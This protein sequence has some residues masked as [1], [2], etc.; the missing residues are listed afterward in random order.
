LDTG[1]T[2]GLSR[3]V[4][5]PV[6]RA[7]GSVGHAFHAL[8]KWEPLARPSDT[9][10]GG[11]SRQTTDQ[12]LSVF[13][14]WAFPDAGFEVYGEL[15]RM[16]LPRS[17]R[18][19][20]VA[21]QNTQGY[22]V[23]LQSVRSAILPRSFVRFQAE[24]TY[25]EQAT[26]LADRPPPDYYTGRAAVQG[27]TQ[28]GRVI[29]AATGPGSSSQWVAAD[30]LAP[31]WQAGIFIGR[32]RW[33]NDVLYRSSDPRVTRHDVTILSGLRGGL[34]LPFMDALSE[35]TIG[36]RLNYLFQNEAYVPGE[37]AGGAIDVQ[38]ITLSILLT[39]R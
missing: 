27:Y 39:P 20:L 6:S 37:G 33:E 17:L 32:T 26:V 34:R 23:G 9:L 18:E 10:A 22:L 31:R 30:F 3:V 2:I 5:A 36:R 16:E 4:Y 38:N 29:G 8:T 28:R 21:P 14:R 35:L 1:L 13:G 11:R 12:L 15:S 25:L 19:W 7:S 24:L